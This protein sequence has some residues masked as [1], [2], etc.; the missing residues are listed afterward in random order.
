MCGL[1]MPTGK[2][3]EDNWERKPIK[4][5]HVFFSCILCLILLGKNM[6][7]FRQSGT[8]GGTGRREWRQPEPF[9]TIEVVTTRQETSYEQ[10]EL[11]KCKQSV[12]P[13]LCTL[14]NRI[15][16]LSI[17]KKKTNN[18]KEKDNRFFVFPCAFFLE[19]QSFIMQRLSKLFEEGAP[20]SSYLR[21]QNMFKLNSKYCDYGGK[22]STAL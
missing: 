20:S 19:A 17:K 9:M 21:I 16:D 1:E 10:N 22:S 11:L 7:F 13:D 14:L 15:L 4:K 3:T 12:L 5:K 6:S 2:Q 18:N 8:R